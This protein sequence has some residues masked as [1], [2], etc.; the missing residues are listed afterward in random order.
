MGLEKE[1]DK[2]AWGEGA[3][4]SEP[5]HKN[6]NDAATGLPCI[7]HRNPHS[8]FWC[9]YVAVNPG[10]PAHSMDYDYVDVE[11]HGGLTYA[12]ECYG[13]ICHVPAPGEPDDV[14]W[15]G[16]DCGHAGDLIP[17]HNDETKAIFVGYGETYKPLPYVESECASLA[18]QL[19]AMKSSSSEL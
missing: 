9:G 6:W 14:W 19:V 2:S 5:D 13:K 16:F 1:I 8:G 3:W 7:A 17:A 4:Q 10:H 18:L 11:V 12:S 15:L